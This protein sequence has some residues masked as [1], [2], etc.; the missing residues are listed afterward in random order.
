MGPPLAIAP[1]RPHELEA[2][3]RLV[4]RHVADEERADR[5]ANALRMV[6]QGDLDPA[7]VLVATDGAESV[8][9]IVCLPVP[10]ASGLLWPPQ[11]LEGPRQGEVE[12]ALVGQAAAWLRQHGAKLAQCLLSEAELPLAEPLPRNGFAHVTALRYMQ[13]DLEPFSMPAARA[14]RLQ[15]IPYSQLT[16]PRLFRETLMHSYEGTEDCPEITGVRTADEIIEGHRAQGKYD[17][18]RWWLALAAGQPVGVLLLT[19]VPEWAAWDV[20]Y[21]GVV[22]RARRRGYGR[23]LMLKAL[24]EAQRDGVARM[25]LSVDARNRAAWALYTD[26]GFQACDRREVFLAI[27]R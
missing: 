10:G 4:F 12:D 14:E 11:A 9:A 17:P 3:F 20:A 16:T 25:T 26:L 19:E 8:G 24:A 21:V 23:E 13:R 27:W 6:R 1:A 2:V 18:G 22:P 15:Y 5:I 7:G